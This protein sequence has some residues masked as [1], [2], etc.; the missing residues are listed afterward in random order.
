MR[1]ALLVL[2]VMTTLF[3]AQNGLAIAPVPARDAVVAQVVARL[4][5]PRFAAESGYQDAEAPTPSTMALLFA[6]LAG[7]TIAGTRRPG[8]TERL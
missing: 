4:D 2:A 3:T 7:L 1:R 8:T 6:G 5:E